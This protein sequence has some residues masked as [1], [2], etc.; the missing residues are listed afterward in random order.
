MMKGLG[1]ITRERMSGKDSEILG[2]HQTGRSEHN[3]LE[4]TLKQEDKYF[5]CDIHFRDHI[6]KN[7]FT[8][9]TKSHFIDSPRNLHGFLLFGY[10]QNKSKLR[11][12]STEFNLW[13]NDQKMDIE[14]S[15]SDYNV[16][17]MVSLQFTKMDLY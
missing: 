4:V 9:K 6:Q 12:I 3:I 1:Y 11:F 7:E 8:I 13:K 16:K 5:I 15:L 10:T 14:I 2:F 17:L